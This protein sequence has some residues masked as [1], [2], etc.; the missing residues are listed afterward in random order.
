MLNE[1]NCNLATVFHVF[2]AEAAMVMV[3]GRRGIGPKYESLKTSVPCAMV[4]LFCYNVSSSE[5][6]DLSCRRQ[7]LL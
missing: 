4:A 6:S 3:C 2:I 7:Q 1:L 5:T